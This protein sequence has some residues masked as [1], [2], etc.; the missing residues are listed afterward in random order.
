MPLLREYAEE[1]LS[2][3]RYRGRPLAPRTSDLYR[4]VLDRQGAALLRRA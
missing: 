1:F 2:T 3:R 4:W